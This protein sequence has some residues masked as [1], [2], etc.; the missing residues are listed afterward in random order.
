MEDGS[1]D[2]GRWFMDDGKWMMVGVSFCFFQINN[3]IPSIRYLA[4]N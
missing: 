1:W 4:Y 2:N 3:D